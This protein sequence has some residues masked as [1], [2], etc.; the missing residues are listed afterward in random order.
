MRD[1][2]SAIQNEL[3]PIPL[4]SIPAESRPGIISSTQ[5]FHP[6]MRDPSEMIS[7]LL[8]ECRVG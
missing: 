5:E 8:K 7:L 3:N 4:D 2:F 6:Q 1:I